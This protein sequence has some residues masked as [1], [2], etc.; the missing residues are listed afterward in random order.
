VTEVNQA[1]ETTGENMTRATL[2][3]LPVVLLF[4]GCKESKPTAASPGKQYTIATVVKLDG[5]GWVDVTK[6]NMDAYSF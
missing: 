1:R 4:V 2:W 5:I 6:E 3:L